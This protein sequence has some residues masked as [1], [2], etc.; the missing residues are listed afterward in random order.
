DGRGLSRHVG[1]GR[2]LVRFCLL[3]FLRRDIGRGWSR[4]VATCRARKFLD[5]CDMTCDRFG[6]DE[7][8]FAERCFLSQAVEMAFRAVPLD[9]PR[10]TR[11]TRVLVADGCVLDGE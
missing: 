8:L 2:G 4:H 11:M 10:R 9:C 7:I 3:A 5:L 6:R 1:A